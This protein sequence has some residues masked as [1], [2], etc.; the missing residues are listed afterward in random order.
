MSACESIELRIYPKSL[1][2]LDT[3]HDGDGD[4]DNDDDDVD[5][6]MTSKLNFLLSLRQKPESWL[7]FRVKQGGKGGKRGGGRR[8]DKSARTSEHFCSVEQ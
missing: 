7:K 2:V 1:F 3:S 6:L 5:L 4:D 8:V